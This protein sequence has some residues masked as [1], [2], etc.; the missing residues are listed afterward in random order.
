MLTIPSLF[1]VT[2]CGEDIGSDGIDS[3]YEFTRSIDNAHIKPNRATDEDF[4]KALDAAKARKKVKR[5]DRPMKGTGY[6]EENNGEHIGETALKNSV[7]SVPIEL[8]TVENT[9]IPIGHYKVVG[10]KEKNDVFLEFYQGYTLVAK[11]PATETQSDFGE[12]TINFVRL[13]PYNEKKVQIIY[14]S[15]DLNA[16]TYI[17]IRNEISD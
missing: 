13:I 12:Q 9:E 16:Y 11:V 5:K 3:N 15:M 4:K 14:G 1:A 6:N 7:V 2:A 10:K 8:L 17:K